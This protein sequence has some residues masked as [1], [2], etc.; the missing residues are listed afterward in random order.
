MKTDSQRIAHYNARM[1]SSTIDPTIAAKQALAAANFGF[2]VMAFYP[3]QQ[4]LRALLAG[5]AIPTI[6]YGPYEAF[7]GKIFHLAQTT[8][9]PSAITSASI[10]VTAWS[11]YP[12]IAVLSLKAICNLY[13]IV[14]P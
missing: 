7:H 4:A 9:G 2:Y 1:V 5:M 12:N 11:S 6:Q 10:L 8:T 14:V 3:K 13:G